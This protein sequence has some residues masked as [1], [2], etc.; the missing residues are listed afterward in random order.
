M[1]DHCP[2]INWVAGK[3]PPTIGRKRC[4]QVIRPRSS[5]KR[6]GVSRPPVRQA[7]F[8]LQQEGYVEVLFRSGWRVLPFN[9]D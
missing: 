1:N 8:K 9:F 2:E 4:S 3:R 7:L 5:S 6:S